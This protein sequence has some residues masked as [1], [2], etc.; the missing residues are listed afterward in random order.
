LDLSAGAFQISGVIQ[1]LQPPHR[2]LLTA[3]HEGS[4]LLGTEKTMPMNK[5]DDRSVALLQR[6][7]RNCGNTF[8]TR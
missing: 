8:E 3:L 4:Y 2:L 6:K 5:P 7:G 1:Q